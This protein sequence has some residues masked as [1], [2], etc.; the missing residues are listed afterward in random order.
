MSWGCRRAT[1]FLDDVPPGKAEGAAVELAT[2]FRPG[3]CHALVRRGEGAKAE[4]IQKHDLGT[5]PDAGQYTMELTAMAEALSRSEFPALLKQLGLKGAPNKVAAAAPVPPDVENRLEQ[6]GFVDQVAALRALHEAI[7]TDGE[8]PARLAALARAYAQLGVLSE[9]QWSP[10]H[11]AFKARALLYAERLVAHDPK[12][13]LALRSRAFVRALVGRH[14]LALADLDEAK[15]L[16]EGTKDA[17]PAPSWLPVIDAYLKA[18][19][20]A[21]AIKDGPHARLAALLNMMTVEYPVRTRVRV[22]AAREVVSRDADCCGAYDAICESGQLGDL[23]I[24]TQI[25]PDA[26]T[27]LFPIKLKSLPALPATVRQPLEKNADELTSW[28]RSTRRAG[29]ATMRAS[30]P[31]PCWRTWPARPA[32]CTPG[33]GWTSWPTSG[34]CPSVTTSTTSSRSSPGI[35]TTHF[36]KASPCLRKRASVRSP[37][38]PTA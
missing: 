20:K 28:A 10:A 26:F 38:S 31:G 29:P 22:E 23:H 25:G 15:K 33:A 1:K 14:D 6:L 4:V 34:R 32:L 24:A 5:N 3:E 37:R 11:R 35:A 8:S 19:R 21:L 2:L 27:K 16:D 9:Y 7:R 12:S 18:D 36:C 13:A 17:A 30:R